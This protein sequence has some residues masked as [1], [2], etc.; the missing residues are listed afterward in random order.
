[1]RL[2]SIRWQLP[3]SYA[4]VALVAALA[5]GGVLLSILRDYYG[6][7]ELDYLRKNALTIR[8]YLQETEALQGP[9]PA[10]QGQLEAFAFLASA[11]V[12]VV[13]QRG[14][15]LADTGQPNDQFIALGGLPGPQFSERASA[16]PMAL[17]TADI[18]STV[19]ITPPQ[20]WLFVRAFPGGILLGSGVSAP[21]QDAPGSAARGDIQRREVIRFRD[22]PVGSERTRSGQ[23]VAAPVLAATGELLGHVE[24]SGGPA[25]GHEILQSVARGW[26]LAGGF[27]VLLATVA[28]WLASRRISQPIL[29]L[30]AATERMAHGDLA[31]RAAPSDRVRELGALAR[32]LNEMAGG[33]EGTLLTLRRFV[34]DA[35]HQLHTP[36]TA[37]RTDLELAIDNETE[38]RQQVRL[39]RAQGQ[40]ERLQALADELLEL[41]RVEA[42]ANQGQAEVLDLVQL[43]EEAIE[44]MASRADQ[45][46]IELQVHAPGRPFL[47]A[48]RAAQLRTLVDNLLDN[49]LKFT[50]AGGTVTV[51]LH[52]EGEQAVLT[53]AD[54]GIGIAD[55]DLPVLFSRFHRG[56]NA[57]DYPGSGLGLA[58]VR[59]VVEGHRG[60]V[61]AAPASPGAQFTVTL[62][63]LGAGGYAPSVTPPP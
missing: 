63:L 55:E 25:Y 38:E 33:I 1:M 41:S 62:P 9:R 57:V 10:L 42:G 14:F 48:G 43:V 40:A 35:A 50:P 34:S 30:A 4:A 15:P 49:A 3:L 53:V 45:C 26:A 21:V 18:T 23:S 36:L 20:D 28:G 17:D 56:R 37:L 31:V 5:L 52:E 8:D 16:S 22:G 58:I 61:V 44:S 11:R 46:R 7:M 29:A 12:R 47:L 27:A 51:E 60:T 19:P 6:R 2:N 59:A 13:D 54:T 32:S 39:R 24:L